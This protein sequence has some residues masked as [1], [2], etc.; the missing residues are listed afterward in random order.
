MMKNRLLIFELFCFLC[1]F[2]FCA[3][4][5]L[6]HPKKIFSLREIMNQTTS[7][8][9]KI[10]TADWNDTAEIVLPAEI[11]RHFHSDSLKTLRLYRDA[12]KSN[13]IH[14]DLYAMLQQAGIDPSHPKGISFYT[15]GVNQRPTQCK[16]QIEAPG[17]RRFPQKIGPMIPAGGSIWRDSFS[18]LKSIPPGTTANLTVI[19]PDAKA[20]LCDVVFYYSPGLSW[21]A[22]EE[23]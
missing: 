7:P 21:W 10:I 3:G 8:N 14:F 17:W 20:F 5:W 6:T 15:I 11:A 2:L 1:I 4:A 18:L 23:Q 12:G 9:A 16:L 19:N 13:E 22:K